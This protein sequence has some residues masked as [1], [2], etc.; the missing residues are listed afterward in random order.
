LA[1]GHFIDKVPISE[2]ELRVGQELARNYAQLSNQEGF[3]RELIEKKQWDISVDELAKEVTVYPIQG[4]QMLVVS[5]TGS[6]Y[7]K[8]CEVADEF[9]AWL[10]DYNPPNTKA[11]NARPTL[12]SEI[13]ALEAEIAAA[14]D[15]Q[16][17]LRTQIST[18]SL[19]NKSLE[20]SLEMT[21]NRLDKLRSDYLRYLEKLNSAQRILILNP[22]AGPKDP[23]SPVLWLNIVS[24]VFG[25]LFFTVIAI[26]LFEY[27]FKK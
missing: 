11:I 13:E 4:T 25:S 26:L 14:R 18:G 6:D 27:P 20:N 7:F 16:N 12:T 10:K 8:A 9:A 3:L 21:E 5:V 1:V 22:A 24:A 19:D 15:L 17:K 2:P 23:V